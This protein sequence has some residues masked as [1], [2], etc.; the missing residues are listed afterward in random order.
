MP[1]R[2][3][4]TRLAAAERVDAGLEGGVGGQG[5]VEALAEP[6]GVQADERPL[7]VEERAAGRTRRQRRRVLDAAGDP[8]AARAAE[9]PRDRRDDAEGDARAAGGVAAAPNTDGADGQAVAG[10]PRERRGAGRVDVDDG[11]V[12]V[13]VDP[14]ERA[15]RSR[16]SANVTV[17]SSPRM[18]WAFVRTRPSAT[19][20]AGAALPREPI[21]TTDGPALARRRRRPPGARRGRSCG[22]LLLDPRWCRPELARSID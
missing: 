6:V 13:D 12:A 19:T 7:G 9:R 2:G 4:S 8:P 16:P 18:L 22:T 3:R 11:E 15:A 10:A 5:E 17:T 1:S 21:P 20:D 14:G